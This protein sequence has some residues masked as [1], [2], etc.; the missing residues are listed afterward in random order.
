MKIKQSHVEHM[1]E[2]IDHLLEVKPW[3]VEE[4]KEVCHE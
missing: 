3:L 1:R 4:S 2:A